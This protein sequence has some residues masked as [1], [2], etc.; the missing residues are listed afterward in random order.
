VLISQD[1]PLIEH[2]V[3]QPDGKWLYDS[4]HGLEAAL[5]LRSVGCVLALADVYADV[6]FAG[7]GS[8]AASA[9]VEFA[10]EGSDAASADVEFDDQTGEA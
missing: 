8:D 10:G 5:E 6:E 9:D 4:A 1:K 7:E 3:R 2:Y